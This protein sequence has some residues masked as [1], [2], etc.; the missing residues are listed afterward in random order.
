MRN[1]C[2]NCNSHT[3]LGEYKC[4]KCGYLHPNNKK[5]WFERPIV[6]DNKLKLPENITFQYNKFHPEA[7]EWL[8]KSYV[9][10]KLVNKYHIGYDNDSHAVFLPA[11]EGNNVIFYQMRYLDKYNEIKYK[12]FGKTSTHTIYYNNFNSSQV[13]IVED[14]LS[15]IRVGEISNV[16]CLSGTGLTQATR[17]LLNSYDV[18]IFWLDPDNP[19]QLATY[20]MYNILNKLHI[21]NE[22]KSIYLD[23]LISNKAYYKVNHQVVTLD[24]KYYPDSYIK[25]VLNM[26]IRRL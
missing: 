9:F 24:P 7:I 26:Y 23:K 10:E 16:I 14:M 4:F 8:S 3:A 13:V 1:Q 15:A 19:G 2:P 22:I 25:E 20:K 17:Q 6:S 18:Y 21:K 5:T 12:T 11:M